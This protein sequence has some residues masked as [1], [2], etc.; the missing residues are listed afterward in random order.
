MV[1]AATAAEDEGSTWA[2]R[3]LPDTVLVDTV[4]STVS[5]GSSFAL[6][7]SFLGNVGAGLDHRSHAL[8]VLGLSELR[9]CGV[10][11][12]V[13]PS[14]G[15]AHAAPPVRGGGVS[16]PEGVQGGGAGGS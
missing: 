11:W 8:D 9:R 3:A 10:P 1:I 7:L 6:P 14:D 15:V 16:S 12:G 5:A 13:V 4:A 2:C